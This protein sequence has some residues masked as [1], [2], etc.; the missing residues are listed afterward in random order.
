MVPG[1]TSISPPSVPVTP[2]PSHL[3][4]NEEALG[5]QMLPQLPD[6]T[7]YD[8][9]LEPIISPKAKHLYVAFQMGRISSGA[10]TN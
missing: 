10:G 9:C 8:A 5:D 7:N 2:P 6:A 1:S 3:L 4:T